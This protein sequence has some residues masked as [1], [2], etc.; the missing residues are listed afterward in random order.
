MPKFLAPI[1]HSKLES[2]NF[3]FQ[4]LSAQPGSPAV[5]QAFYD[6]DTNT[7]FYWNGGSW[8]ELST[9][10]GLTQEQVEDFVGA[11]VAGNV[12]TGI[13]VTY[14]DSGG[15]LDFAVSD[16]YIQDLIG[17][18]FSGNTETRISAT[19]DDTNGKID[20]V[21]DALS[22][23]EVQDVVGA[24]IV[25]GNNID[26]TYDDGAGTVTID[27]E[28]LTS[29]D[30][31]D[32]A[33]AVDERARDAV[34]TAL[35]AGNNIDITVN[36]G[37]DTVTI[38]VESLTSG[39]LTD[40]AEA[41]SDQVGTMVTGNTETGITV[42][43]D[44]SDNT[45]DFVV[46]ALNTLPAPTGDLSLNGQKITGLAT[47]TA[48]TDAATKGYVD[49][50][51]NGV[52]WKAAVRVATTAAGTLASSFENGDTVDGVTL[53]TG[54]R[55]L[56]KNQASPS[57]NGIY[58]VN[59][60]GAPTR[61]TDA[62]ASA[63][64]TSGI[65]VWVS[66]GTTNGETG[67]VLATDDPITLGTTALTFIQFSGAGQITAGNALTKTGNT[68]DVV[69]GTGLEI[70]SDTIRIAAAAAGSG[71]TGGAGSALDVNVGSGLEISSDAVRI[72]AA[73]AGN[74][75]T[76]GAGSA[77]AV[78]AGTGIVVTADAVAVDRTGTN[79][80]HVPLKYSQTVGDGA[81][82]SIAVT[83]NLGTRAVV[84]QV[85][86]SST[87]ED[88]LVDVVRTSTS[89]VTLTFAVAPASAAYTAV[90]FG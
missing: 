73:A 71:L 27:V 61:A 38:D 35:V 8:V 41:V 74:G 63:E 34:G 82:T 84:V 12:E 3:R 69:A 33:T 4:N 81:A 42:S 58:T 10:S 88:V 9:S 76:G 15:K 1:D 39:D 70:S 40:F 19:Y 52:D 87:F 6:T 24:M 64:V 11:M 44:D 17:A 21:V 48:D 75:L 80:A 56:V 62:D 59:A 37:A 30:I 67:W 46:G 79:G 13:S 47:P 23:E 51:A 20:L 14:D 57:E 22:A 16:E 2:L 29:A 89:V 50:L 45:L 68:L 32:F 60:S 77:L 26:V 78:G 28:S 83:H 55:I 85:F 25:A 7:I 36:D 31:T 53:A 49:G 43:Y 54:D 90:I 65:A 86:D 18:M 66:E 5:G 72:A